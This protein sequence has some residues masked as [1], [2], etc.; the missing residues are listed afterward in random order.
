MQFQ[1]RNR[2]IRPTLHSVKFLLFGSEFPPPP[3]QKKYNSKCAQFENACTAQQVREGI[4]KNVFN[5][6]G[7]NK[8]IRISVWFQFVNNVNSSK[9][10][11]H[12]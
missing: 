10:I 2:L 8:L 3:P 1:A 7:N 6:N 11:S 9:I 12:C 4:P 5:S